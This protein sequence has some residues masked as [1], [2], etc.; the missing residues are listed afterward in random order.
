VECLEVA[1]LDLENH[2]WPPYFV[3]RAEHHEGVTQLFGS[4][5]CSPAEG[6]SSNRAFMS[7]A[8]PRAPAGEPSPAGPRVASDTVCRTRNLRERQDCS[9]ML[10]SSLSTLPTGTRCAPLH[11]VARKGVGVAVLDQ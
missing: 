9:S 3:T 1:K 4:R 8:V 7:R 11:Q 6:E 10:T 2:R 5:R